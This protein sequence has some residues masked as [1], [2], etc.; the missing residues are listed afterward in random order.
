MEGWRGGSEGEWDS[1]ESAGARRMC[2][3][4]GQPRR[5]GGVEARGRG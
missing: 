4:K 3:A 1:D 2:A 5:G